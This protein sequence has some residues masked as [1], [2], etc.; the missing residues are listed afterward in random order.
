MMVWTVLRR[1]GLSLALLLILAAVAIEPVSAKPKFSALAVDARTGEILFSSDA[2]GSRYPASLTKVMT[3]YILF[4]EM[5]AGRLTLN[6]RIPVSRYAAGR[7]PTKLG[8]NAGGTVSVEEAIKAL[9]VLSAND[10]AVAVG[11]RIEGS[12]AAFAQRMTR[13]AKTLGM[14]R[15]NFRNASGLPDPRQV[16]TARDIATLSLRVQRDFP[17]YFPYFRTTSF[18]YGKRVIR[19]HNR[20]LGRFEGTDGIKT[21][22]IRAAGFNLTTSAKRGDK[23]IIGVVMGGQTGRSRDNYMIAM[24]NKA[25]PKCVGG[26]K[27]AT[28][29]EGTKPGPSAEI[30]VASIESPPVSAATSKPA[31]KRRAGRADDQMP[32]AEGDVGGLD[33]A[34]L[35]A[36][37]Q[38]A[39]G[40][41]GT[42]YAAVSADQADLARVSGE[43]ASPD[44]TPQ[45]ASLAPTQATMS[46]A[47]PFKVKKPAET[48][49]GQVIVA[50]VASTWNIQLGAYA[51][52]K[53]AQDALYAARSASPK[54]FSDKQAFT[55]EV[56]K[57][58]E[59]IFR[60]R[61]SG[62]TAKGAKSA[63]KT[64]SRKGVDCSTLA[65]QS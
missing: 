6:S 12:E 35:A 14:S 40:L 52:K 54:L 32:E 64:L 1:V 17:Q 41:A 21:G 8:V 16:T 9:V 48:Q 53:E 29:I 61:M 42:T 55:I 19:S 13:T 3:L 45:V 58:E 44:A 62:F 2:D 30:Q 57:G 23:R 43:V 15:T 63:C 59:T 47:L 49:G 28:A 26:T 7:P 27:L 20:L 65:P 22:Y 37:A 39:S 10:I 38:S 24:L 60:A 50:S 4:Q 36:Q 25:F 18:A 46:A 33:S 56:K 11:E 31:K 5:K 51:S 34:E